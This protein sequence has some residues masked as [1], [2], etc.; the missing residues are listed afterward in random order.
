MLLRLYANILFNK[1]NFL[2]LYR[3]RAS[4][5]LFRTEKI[6]QTVKLLLDLF[7]M[8][9]LSKRSHLSSQSLLS[10]CA[11]KYFELF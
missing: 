5:P 8:N 6:E 11:Q 10:S 9:L 2:F 3:R 1:L 7:R 4:N